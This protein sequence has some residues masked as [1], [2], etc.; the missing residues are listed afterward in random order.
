MGQNH[1]SLFLYNLGNHDGDNDGHDDEED[2]G[3]PETD[4][5]HTT[6]SPC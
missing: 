6:S 4:P 3:N 5:S 1:R 2:D